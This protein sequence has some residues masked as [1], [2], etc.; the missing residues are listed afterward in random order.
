M[1]SRFHIIDTPLRGLKLVERRPIADTRGY[2]ERMFCVEELRP[3][4]EGRSIVQINHSL[5]E[6]QGTVR[7]LHYQREPDAEMKIVSCLKG[8]IFDVAVDI[9]PGSPTFLHWHGEILSAA[10]HRMLVIPE[11]FAH[12]FQVIGEGSEI[13]YL[14]TAP[15][16]PECEGGLHALDPLL[17]IAWPYPVSELSARDAAQVK[18]TE[19]AL[20]ALGTVVA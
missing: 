12:G 19:T 4:I 17:G 5:T 3:L 14:V 16:A 9:R 18:L 7:G 6:K 1:S 10:N 11:G 8:E 20:N 15:Y 2:F 13:M